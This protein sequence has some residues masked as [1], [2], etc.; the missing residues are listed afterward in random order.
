MKRFLFLA[1]TYEGCGCVV[2]VLVR[3][4]GILL[5]TGERRAIGI[6][7]TIPVRSLIFAHNHNA[8]RGIGT[9]RS[10]LLHHMIGMSSKFLLPYS[11]EELCYN[12]SKI[13]PET[14]AL[15]AR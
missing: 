6:A 15:R 1:V 9:V 12:C 13:K 10:F 11:E 8:G 7:I 14:Y 3:Y 4:S 2:S 5:V